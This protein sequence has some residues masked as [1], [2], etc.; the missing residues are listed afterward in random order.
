MLSEDDLRQDR[1][2]PELVE[3]KSKVYFYPTENDSFG[4]DVLAASFFL[5]S[6]YEEYLE[7]FPDEHQRFTARESFIQ[8]HLEKPLVNQWALMLK[9][10][11]SQRYPEL[12]FAPRKFEYLSTIDIDQAWKF[13][14]KGLCRNVAGFCKDLIEFKWENARMRWP[15]V[16]RLR[17][18]PFYNFSWQDKLHQKLGTN[19]LYFLLL[20]DRSSYDKNIS[21]KDPYFRALIRKLGRQPNYRLGIHPS[22]LSNDEPSQ[23]NAEIKRLQTLIGQKPATS[24]QHFLKHK[25]PETY[26]RLTAEGITEEHSMGYS[27]H[28][29]FRAG[30]AAPFRFYDLSSEQST[31]LELIPFCLMDITPMHYLELSVEDAIKKSKAL[32][33]EVKAVG[34]LFVSL[35]HNESLSETEG[36]KGWRPVYEAMLTE[37]V[38]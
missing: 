6:R 5:L 30:I 7:F 37:A 19:V 13:R 15:V 28:M 16:S 23:L 4:F 26:H 22:Y 8:D 1:K 34:G 10:A 11:L 3:E 24:R 2:A 12:A 9:D 36:W 29:G 31:S 17:S 32:M 18:D 38:L 20:G 25:F 14:R 21:W 35:W 27:T 33:D